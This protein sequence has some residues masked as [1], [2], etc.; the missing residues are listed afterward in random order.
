[1]GQVIIYNPIHAVIHISYVLFSEFTGDT[2]N[3]QISTNVA[4]HEPGIVNAF[5]PML[6][7]P[8]NINFAALGILDPT[9]D[10]KC[11]HPD[12]LARVRIR[13]W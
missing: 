12:I 4:Y 8:L 2:S 11:Y 13:F 5:S 1:V 3:L 9:D 10:D 6:G 7:M